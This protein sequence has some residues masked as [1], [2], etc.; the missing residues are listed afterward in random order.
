MLCGGYRSDQAVPRKGTAVSDQ[1]VRYHRH[2]G[3]ATVRLC[4][5][6]RNLGHPCQV[7]V[8]VDSMSYKSG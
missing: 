1:P 8:E 2:K 3:G 7:A 4:C 6:W 5:K